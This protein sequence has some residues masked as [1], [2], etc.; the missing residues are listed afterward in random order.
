MCLAYLV[1]SCKLA[2]SFSVSQVERINHYE[3][4][5]FFQD[6]EHQLQEN[7]LH[8]FLHYSFL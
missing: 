4:H 1:L 5:V 7:D 6:I 2:T 8:H 3:I